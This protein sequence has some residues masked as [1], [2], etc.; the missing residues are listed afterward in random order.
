[1][2]VDFTVAICTYNGAKRLPQVLDHL[3]NQ[4]G[5][6]TIQWEILVIDNNSADQ[7]AKIVRSYQTSWPQ[8]YPLRYTFE[9]RQGLALARQ[10]A[11]EE[12]KGKFIGFIDDDN[13]AKPD[14]VASAYAFGQAHPNVGAYG[15]RIY[16]DFEVTP[17]ENF[18]RIASLLALTDR[19][20]KARR[21]EPHKK[22]LPPGAGLVV[23]KDVWL[24]RVPKQCFLQGRVAGCKLPGEDLE[25]LL[26]IQQAGWELWYN[27]K[28]CIHHQIPKGRL[29]KNYLM[30]LCRGIGLSRHHTRML[31]F[32][33]WQRPLIF[34]LYMANDVRKIVLHFFKYRQVL[35][36]D[37]VAACEMQLFVSSLISPFYLWNKQLKGELSP[38]GKQPAEIS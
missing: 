29:E 22:L 9:S 4:V 32:K 31:S 12:A 1:M 30:N 20:S 2:S 24:Q 14:W 16:G 5:T 19:G 21:Y 38:Y 35:K 37:I 10:R 15:S 8:A 36:S 26:Y 6:E 23:R 18:Q 33:L 27:P 3:R 25:A 17:P 11:V 13:L 28:M 7:T 34:P